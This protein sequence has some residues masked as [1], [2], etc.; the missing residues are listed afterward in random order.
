MINILCHVLRSSIFH[1]NRDSSPTSW[2]KGASFPSKDKKDAEKIPAICSS[3]KVF[4]TK[5]NDQS[6]TESQKTT[7]KDSFCQNLFHF[8]SWPA[9]VWQRWLFDYSCPA[10]MAS[11]SVWSLHVSSL[12][13]QKVK[14]CQ[15]FHRL[16]PLVPIRV[17]KW[18]SWCMAPG[19]DCVPQ[20]LLKE[21]C[22]GMSKLRCL[23]R[24]AKAH[25]TTFHWWW[26]SD[27]KWLG[28]EWRR[29]VFLR[30]AFGAH[31]QLC[32]ASSKNS[33]N[34]IRI[35][36]HWNGLECIVYTVCQLGCDKPCT[37]NPNVSLGILVLAKFC[38]PVTVASQK[39]LQGQSIGGSKAQLANEKI[40]KQIQIP[41]ISSSEACE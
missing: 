33:I 2:L 8:W 40:E 29:A 19:H 16:S 23:K 34:S 22:L 39:A 18:M 31:G 15:S 1:K 13:P 11:L 7:L 36:V 12:D 38:G 25:D 35:E 28:E 6:E 4:V 30:S 41:L 5:W 9:T 21:L 37:S 32:K 17:A 14:I 27:R 3:K 20:V 24:V 10:V 26:K